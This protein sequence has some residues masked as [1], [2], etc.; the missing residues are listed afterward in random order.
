[1]AN[2][3]SQLQE[4]PLSDEASNAHSGPVDG[5]VEQDPG[6]RFLGQWNQLV[7]TTNWEKG[8]I[9]CDWREALLESGAAVTDYSDET[10]AQLVGNVTSQHVGRLRRVFQRFGEVQSQYPGLFWSHF[11]AALDW[12]DA[13]MWLEGAIQNDWSVSQMRGR[14]WETLETPP[15]EQRREVAA[16]QAQLDEE[17]KAE[18]AVDSSEVNSVQSTTAT[19]SAGTSERAAGGEPTAAS[20]SAAEKSTSEN[21]ASAA[22]PEQPAR[23]EK[24]TKLSVDVENLPDDLAEAFESFKLAI[25]AHR[26]EGWT[27]TTPEAVIACL[28]G[29]RELALANEDE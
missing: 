14:R 9:I 11:Q 21:V 22:A 19:V 23:I 5:N 6:A 12:D 28:D 10:W 18:S 20:G 16:E 25:I 4:T 27:S 1:M 13:E 15:A 29:L 17:S 3:E 2:R 24:R 7:S 26:R 8:R